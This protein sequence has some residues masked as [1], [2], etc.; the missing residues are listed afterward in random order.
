MNRLI[1][2]SFAGGVAAL[3]E[4]QVLGVRVLRPVLELQQLDLQLVLLLLVD[5]AVEPL[6]VGVV[7]APGLDRVAPRV[8]EVGVGEVLVVPD[9][10]AVTQQ[11]VQVLPEVFP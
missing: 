11:M 3:E 2:P 5:V 1:V 4:D 6:V 10:V 8:D 7:L 9:A